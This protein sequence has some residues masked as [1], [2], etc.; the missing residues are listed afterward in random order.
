MMECHLFSAVAVMAM[1]LRGEV[2]D[3]PSALALL[4][5]APRLGVG[6]LTRLRNHPLPATLA[7]DGMRE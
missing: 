4:H 7:D 5:C 1:V 6:D 3:G 2:T